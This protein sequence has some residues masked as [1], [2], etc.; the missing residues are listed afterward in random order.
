MGYKVNS[1]YRNKEL[2]RLIKPKGEEGSLH[3]EGLAADISPEGKTVE[4]LVKDINDLDNDNID[5][6]K[7]Y[8]SHAHVRFKAAD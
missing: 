8:D 4:Q 7:R 6:V 1:A 5:W 2:N 3:I